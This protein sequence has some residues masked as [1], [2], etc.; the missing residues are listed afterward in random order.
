MVSFCWKLDIALPCGK[1]HGQG[2]QQLIKKKDRRAKV[3]NMHNNKL[4]C[5]SCKEF[6]WW[7]V[8][9]TLF[10]ADSA[11]NSRDENLKAGRQDVET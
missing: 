1:S 5:G 7:G 3:Q 11:M 6:Q 9:D 4:T 2:I 8:H 10:W